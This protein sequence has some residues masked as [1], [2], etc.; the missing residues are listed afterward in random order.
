MDATQ[1]DITTHYQQPGWF[2]RN[3]FNRAVA[4]ATRLGIS[5]W[6]SR[7]LRV[8]GRKSGAVRTT[9]VNLLEIEGTQYLVAPR[10]TTQ[11][12]RNMRAA[13]G[14]ELRLGRR[15][16]AFRAVEIADDDKV[17]VLRSYLRR[18]KMEVGVFFQGVGPDSTDDELRAIADQ[19]P[20]F[21]VEA[22]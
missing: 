15:V 20:V 9:P 5:V 3:V 1:T 17:A 4:V 8:V 13:G 19:H 14:G 16:E 6:G 2:T 12:V 10:G 21:R 18:W 22:A 7:E 11:W